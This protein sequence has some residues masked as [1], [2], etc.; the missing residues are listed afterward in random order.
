[1]TKL[2]ELIDADLDAVIGGAD[3]N[4]HF[5]WNGP[6]GTGA[7]PLNVSCGPT[8]QDIYQ[9]WADLGRRLGGKA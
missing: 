1:M 7:Y 6:A 5:C 2:H 4:Y 9:G 8:W 3:P